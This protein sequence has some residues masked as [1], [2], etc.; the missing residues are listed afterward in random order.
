MSEL[1]TQEE[2]DDWEIEN[3]KF[4]DNAAWLRF[5]EAYVPNLSYLPKLEDCEF[6]KQA[7]ICGAFA[8]AML[9]E[10]KERGRL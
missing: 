4:R 1:P 3:K 5:A 9:A 2:L 10:A 7:E 6:E 8:D